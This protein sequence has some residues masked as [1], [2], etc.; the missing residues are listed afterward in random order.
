METHSPQK[1]AV[2]TV[3]VHGESMETARAIM[4]LLHE[5]ENLK[6]LQRS[7]WK[8]RNVPNPESV[9]EHSFRLTVMTFF[10]PVRYPCHYI[11]LP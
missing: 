3:T 4:K 7:G 5:V 2:E 8:I 11:Y 6:R 9:A 10:A 1:E